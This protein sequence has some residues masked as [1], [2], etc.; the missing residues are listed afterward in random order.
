MIVNVQ[1]ILG[2]ENKLNIA[3]PIIDNRNLQSGHY[4]PV[5]F[6]V[7]RINYFS[8]IGFFKTQCPYSFFL[9]KSLL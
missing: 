4:S 8:Q 1:Q 6:G 5:K 9:N 2:T 3:N 7:R